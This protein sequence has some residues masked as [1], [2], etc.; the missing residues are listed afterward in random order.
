MAVALAPSAANSD[1]SLD[2][3]PSL[4][5]NCFSWG[6]SYAAHL[7]VV[8]VHVAIPLGMFLSISAAVDGRDQEKFGIEWLQWSRLDSDVARETTFPAYEPTSRAQ[9][10]RLE[11]AQTAEHVVNAVE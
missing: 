5:Q 1:T 8:A 9:R 7:L 3:T 2:A 6:K 11:A 10:H 4:F